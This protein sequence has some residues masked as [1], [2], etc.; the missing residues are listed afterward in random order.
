MLLVHTPGLQSTLQ[1]SARKG[2]RH[3]GIP[4]AGPVDAVSMHLA[5]RL[6]ANR[7]DA[8]SLE[9]T[10][11]GFEAEAQDGCAIAITGATGEITINGKPTASHTTLHLKSGD[12]IRVAPP[13]VGCRSYLA[14]HSGFEADE[15]FNSTST[16]LP[17]GLG[18]HQG[19]CLKVGDV[20][21][22]TRRAT[23][24]S[25]YETPN[26]MR[27]ALSHAFAVRACAASET[28]LL[29]AISQ[30][31]LFGETFIVGRQATR[32]GV[33]LT[34]HKIHPESDGRMQSAPVFPGTIQCPPSGVPIALLS[35]AQ[36]TGGYPRIASVARCD[37]HLLGQ[38]RPGDQIQFLHRTHDAARDAY[39]QKKALLAQWLSA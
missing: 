10:Y 36:T 24:Q 34:G 20:L 4:Y 12:I 9:I 13:I 32:M 1:G 31:C 3:F 27:P 18:G 2:H 39:Q 7:L 22:P 30:A 8:T 38:A 28:H 16:Y 33:S 23:L 19:R 6:V 5:N 17:A 11:G 37:R 21:R 26:E 14:I 15:H 35:D 29:S 25:T